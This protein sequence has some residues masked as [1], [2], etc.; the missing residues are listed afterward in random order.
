MMCQVGGVDAVTIKHKVGWISSWSLFALLV[1]LW[2]VTDPFSALRPRLP[3][4]LT[5]RSALETTLMLGLLNLAA[6]MLFVRPFVRVYDDT[7]VVGNSWSTT[8]VPV[9]KIVG[10]QSDRQFPRLLTEEGRRVTLRALEQS[11]AYRLSHDRSDDELIQE[12]AARA[13]GPAPVEDAVRE[14]RRRPRLWPTRG[15][16]V[17]AAVWALLTVVGVVFGDPSP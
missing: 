1:G 15:E 16:V 2:F 7:W 17:V 4:A 11:L 9:A 5:L 3:D 8:W 13:T 6:F 10:V 12:L 14:V